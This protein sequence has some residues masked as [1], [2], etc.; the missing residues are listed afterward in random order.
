[1]NFG[2]RLKQIRLEKGYTQK[3]IINKINISQNGYSSW[4][5]GK[6]EPNLT[7]LKKLSNIFHISV[8]YL[9]GM[10]NEEGLIIMQNELSEDENYLIDLI[11][12]LEMK[13][14]STI[15]E[16]AEL[17]VQA[18]KIKQNKNKLHKKRIIMTENNKQ[19]IQENKNKE[20][21]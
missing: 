6:T 17:M 2:E 21:R 7:S 13:D 11:R 9:L 12:Q 16:L 3:D 19:E 14:K 8:D 18:K 5:L 4:E 15:Y 1:M 20:L 10:E